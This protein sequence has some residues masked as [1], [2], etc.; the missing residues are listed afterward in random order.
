M[1]C[2]CHVFDSAKSVKL[3][4]NRFLKLKFNKTYFIIFVA[5]LIIEIAIASILS[6]GFIRATFGDFLIVML[7]Y[8][9]LKSFWN[10]KPIIVAITVLAISF[11]I[12]ILQLFKLLK[13][14]HL[15]N[16]QIAKL[17]LGNTFHIADLISYTLGI[18]VVLIIEHKLLS[19]YFKL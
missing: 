18:A 19:Q 13:F 17:I 12:E 11:F 1:L 15:E 14:L 2:I 6:E 3:K 16:N 4:S 10:T 8:Y 9:F 7:L 5:I